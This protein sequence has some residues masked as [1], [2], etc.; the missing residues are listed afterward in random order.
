MHVALTVLRKVDSAPLT[1]QLARRLLQPTP[2]SARVAGARVRVLTVMHLCES[3]VTELVDLSHAQPVDLAGR[4]PDLR[5]N[6]GGLLEHSIALAALFVPPDAVV[7]QTVG[8]V[9]ESK[10]TCRASPALYTRRQR[11]PLALVPAALRR[12]PMV[13][14]MDG[15]TASVAEI[16]A[17]AASAEAASGTCA[18]WATARCCATSRPAG[19]RR[20]GRPS[21]RRAGVRYRAAGRP[22][23]ERS[24]RPAGSPALTAGLWLSH[25]GLAGLP[26]G[27]LMHYGACMQRPFGPRSLP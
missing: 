11:D 22:R 24:P 3:A 6:P 18:T 10:V 14:L 2:A 7:G 9:P 16:V 8:P 23:R 27:G 21:T 15:S 5:G 1:V 25:G 4:V 12:L 26:A 13:V 20:R 19:G 17:G